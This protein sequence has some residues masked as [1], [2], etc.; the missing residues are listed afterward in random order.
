MSV[1]NTTSN[2]FDPLLINSTGE[3]VAP[4][5]VGD[6]TTV[7]SADE[8]AEVTATTNEDELMVLE[9]EGQQSDIAKEYEAQLQLFQ[10][11]LN[12]LVAQSQAIMT[13][14]GLPDAD[15]MELTIQMGDI[16]RAKRDVQAGITQLRAGM[17]KAQFSQHEIENL[18]RQI[19]EISA[20]A[21]SMSIPQGTGTTNT[22]FDSYNAQAGQSLAAHGASVAASTGTTGWCLK[23]V[24]NALE[25]Q[26]GDRLNYA[27]AYQSLGEMRSET[28][29]GQYFEEV[30]VP[31]EDLASLPAGAIVIWDNN[32]DDNGNLV[33][34]SNVSSAGKEWGHISIADGQG[35][36]LSD[37]RNSQMVNR[38]ADFYV[39]I[40]V[41]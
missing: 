14:F 5:T 19:G 30:N 9:E 23:G 31:R 10:Q 33:G 37:H 16:N 12:I 22:S 3:T 2:P 32:Y 15:I 18:E 29:L 4:E 7:L 26:Y 36:E 1:N 38:D 40:P 41:A 25:R 13:K 27:G 6:D 20:S 39:F 24:N 28:G 35:N 17:L 21:A 34:G 11:E 8:T